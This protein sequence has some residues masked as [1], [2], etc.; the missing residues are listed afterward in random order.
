MSKPGPFSYHVG[1]VNV[2]YKPSGV[3]SVNVPA[4][5]GV[6]KEHRLHGMVPGGEYAIS[7]S[8][9]CALVGDAAVATATAEGVLAFVA[10]GSC[11]GGVSAAF[12]G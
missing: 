5:S 1:N 9:A 2:D 7:A 11:A 8:G 4:P 3:T 10:D 6:A 12:R